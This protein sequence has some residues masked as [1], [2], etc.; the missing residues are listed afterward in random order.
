MYRAIP[1]ES[2]VLETDAPFLTPA[3]FRGKICEPKH[4][5]NTLVFLADLRG[6]SQ[7]AIAKATSENAQQLFGIEAKDL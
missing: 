1:T 5:A 6:Q 2:L 7:E 4:V 3:P